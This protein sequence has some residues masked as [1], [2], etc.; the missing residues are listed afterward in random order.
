MLRSFSGVI[1][2]LLISVAAFGQQAQLYRYVDDKGVT[3]LGNRVPPEFVSRGYEVLDSNG[4]VREV[5]PA[6]PTREE[7]KANREAREAQARQRQS[8]TTLLRLYSSQADLD[9]AHARQLAQI[10]SLIQSARGEMDGVQD[11]REALQQRAAVQERAGREVDPQILQ[12]LAHAD[13]E[14]LRLERLI[15]AKQLEIKEVR[16]NF[17]H[18]R[19]RLGY[20][21]GASDS[22][23]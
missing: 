15:E 10:D 19:A 5:I 1:A 17:I 7:L 23:S 21:L 13:D 6:A 22:G 20:L 16:A 4:R 3:V 8:D 9:R 2:G 12:D 11:Q 14:T 18:Q